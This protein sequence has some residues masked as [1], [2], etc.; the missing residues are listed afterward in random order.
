MKEAYIVT[1]TSLIVSVMVTLV[2]VL[3]CLA[4]F[5]VLRRRSNRNNKN[6][7]KDFEMGSM[8]PSPI[9][10]PQNKDQPPPYEHTAGMENKALEHSMDMGLGLDDSKNPMYSQGGYSYHVPRQAPSHPG[11][12]MPHNDCKFNTR[13]HFKMTLNLSFGMDFLIQGNLIIF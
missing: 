3:M 5:V 7:S 11:Q 4:L 2:V 1:M 10:T 9:V 8:K 13:S 12:P 6:G